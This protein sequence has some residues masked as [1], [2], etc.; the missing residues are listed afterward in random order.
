MSDKEKLLVAED[1]QEMAR[2]LK[3]TLA[4]DYDVHLAQETRS[5]L[6]TLKRTKPPVITLDLGLPPQPKGSQV[7]M[8][9]LGKI[10]Q[11]EPSCKIVAVTGNNECENALLKIGHGVWDYCQHPVNVD[12]LKVVLSGA[13]RG[14]RCPRERC[15]QSDHDRMEIGRECNLL[16][17]CGNA[18]HTKVVDLY[19]LLVVCPSSV[20]GDRCCDVTPISHTTRWA[21]AP[22]QHP[23]FGIEIACI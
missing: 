11:L 10:L 21:Y 19:P 3:W 14:E 15:T 9:L 12:E 5:A 23:F 1:D 18:L 13:F 22:A 7:G 17:L 8:E 4:D 6:E 16:P 2:Q 20:E